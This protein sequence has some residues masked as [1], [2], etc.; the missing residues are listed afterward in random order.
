LPRS[1]AR[2]RRSSNENESSRLSLDSRSYEVILQLEREYRLSADMLDTYYLRTDS[3]ELVPMSAVVSQVRE[4]PPQQAHRVPAA[5]F[6]G[7]SAR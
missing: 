3:G 5:Q 1:A 7:L 2:C 6:R 4:K